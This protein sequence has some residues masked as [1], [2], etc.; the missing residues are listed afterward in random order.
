MSRDGLTAVAVFAGT[1]G[2]GGIPVI[3]TL[4]KTK[5][6]MKNNDETMLIAVAEAR[7]RY[8]PCLSERSVKRAIKGVGPATLRAVKVGRTW[9]VSFAEIER[10][11]AELERAG[12]EKSFPGQT[13]RPRRARK[14]QELI[15]SGETYAF[16]EAATGW[17]PEKRQ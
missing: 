2:A 5:N 17:S 16:L 10:F 14:Y 8:F 11:V 15:E 3:F 6:V 12:V 1:S 7:E 4:P 9:V 13:R